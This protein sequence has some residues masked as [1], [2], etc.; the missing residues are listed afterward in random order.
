MKRLPRWAFNFAAAVSAVLLVAACVLWFESYRV[1]ICVTLV[2]DG[3]WGTALVGHGALVF[4]WYHRDAQDIVPVQPAVAPDS[5]LYRFYPSAN[6]YSNL[7]K[8]WQVAGFGSSFHG[9]KDYLLIPL[10][11][12]AVLS[13]ALPFCRLRYLRTKPRL[14]G[15]CPAC[16]YDLR[17]TPGRCPECGTPPK[18]KLAT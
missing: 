11:A 16:G 7:A 9:G 2:H 13:A 5:V 15:H 4:G 17:A 1:L 14:V 10:W 8:R 12:L 18:G 3:R 6:P